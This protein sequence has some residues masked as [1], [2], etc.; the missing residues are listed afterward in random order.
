M[1][2]VAREPGAVAVQTASSTEPRPPDPVSSGL[3]LPL[4]LPDPRQSGLFTE[5]EEGG[6]ER[7]HVGAAANISTE[8][9]V[10]TEANASAELTQTNDT[11]HSELTELRPQLRD[12]AAGKPLCDPGPGAEPDRV[13]FAVSPLSLPAAPEAPE[14][15]LSLGQPNGPDRG[16]TERTMSGSPDP[17]ASGRETAGPDRESGPDLRPGTQVRVSLDH[18]ID[19]ALVV[20]FRVGHKMF[21]GVLM[22]LSRR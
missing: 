22:D 10:S 4:V 2:A 21:S 1:A 18:V 6:A 3:G 7:R 11:Q 9:N 14:A 5:R 15:G 19:D 20:S 8:A 16:C 12:S 17:A 13:Q